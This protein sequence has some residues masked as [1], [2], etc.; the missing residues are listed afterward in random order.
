VYHLI[1]IVYDE[2]QFYT[3][4]FTTFTSVL[5]IFSTIDSYDAPKTGSF[6]IEN[7]ILWAR[8]EVIGSAIDQI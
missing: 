3:A 4:C 6:K 8:S 1:N 5:H 7:L 2:F